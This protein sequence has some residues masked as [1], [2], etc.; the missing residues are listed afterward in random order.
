L[1]ERE[2]TAVRRRAAP[3]LS[4]ASSASV[5][6]VPPRARLRLKTYSAPSAKLPFYVMAGS[7]RAGARRQL[8]PCSFR[9]PSGPQAALRNTVGDT[10]PVCRVGGVEIEPGLQPPRSPRNS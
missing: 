7:A 5:C 9:D 3:A 4:D 6:L 1:Q 2:P 10:A 8:R